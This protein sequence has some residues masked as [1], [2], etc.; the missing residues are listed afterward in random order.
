MPV[1]KKINTNK[2]NNNIKKSKNVKDSNVTTTSTQNNKKVTFAQE[3]RVKTFHK[4]KALLKRKVQ[5]TDDQIEETKKK[6]K[7]AI[8][9]T[10]NKKDTTQVE[11][12]VS[13]DEEEEE[14]EQ[15]EVANDTVLEA[16]TEEQEEALRKEILGDLV[17]D[18]EEEEDD[19]ED[20]SDDDQDD[21]IGENANIVPLTKNKKPLETKKRSTSTTSPSSTTGWVYVGRIPTSFTESDMRT[22]FE[23][24][25][26]IV[27]LRI[28][29]NKYGKSRHYG[30]IEFLA[31]DVAEIVAET[32]DNYL[33]DGRLLQCKVI[34]LELRHRKTFKIAGKKIKKIQN[35]REQYAEKRNKDHDMEYYLKH[36][37]SLVKKEDKKRAALKK[38]NID[39]DFPGYAASQSQ[40]KP[41]FQ[42]KLEQ[43]LKEK[44][45]KQTE[46]KSI[47]PIKA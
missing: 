30:F 33:L 3:K 37:D 10:N 25:G 32:M 47:T 11:E 38:L 39:Y 29:R 21:F 28:S 34:P 12:L 19:D 8:R 2:D 4:D 7:P 14:E 15:P 5:D 35:P 42:A 6:A 41:L 27:N 45:R 1:A 16:L 26:D 24:F 44:E 9:N 18:D 13:S 36:A 40:W 23:Q 22:Y 31:Q 20:S 46:N 43:D 17:D